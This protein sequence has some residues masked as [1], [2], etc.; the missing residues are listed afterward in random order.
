M[1][2]Q[3]LAEKSI[4]GDTLSVAECQAVL[5]CPDEPILEL[6]DAAYRVR[7]EFCGNRVHLHMLI[8]AK[9]GLCPEDCHY[10]AQ[11]RISEA[12]IEKYPMVSMTALLEGARRAA[13]ARSRRYCIVISGRGPTKHEVDY[14]VDAVRRVKEE[15][16]IGIC[17]S[18]GL[19]SE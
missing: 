14:L 12:E 2:F 11:S 5:R 1:R 4:V 13:A 18:V 3:A 8:N 15:V 16:D 7:R 9:S 17:C 6:L 19:L 10:C